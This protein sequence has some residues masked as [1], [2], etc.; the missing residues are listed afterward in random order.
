MACSYCYANRGLFDRPSG[1][2]MTPEAAQAVV[3]SA[4]RNFNSIEVVQFIGGEPTINLPAIECVCAAFAHALDEGKLPYIPRF[5]LTTNALSVSETLLSLART[6][7]VRITVSLDGPEEVH[8]RT[9]RTPDGKGTYRQV[10]SSI[11]R[12]QGFGLPL[13]FE[14]TFSRAH[15]HSGVHLID[16]C[17]WFREEFGLRVLHAPPVSAGSYVSDDLPLTN[18]ESIREYCSAAEW[19]VD[20]FIARN[21]LLA[22]SFTARVLKAVATKSRSQSICSAGSDLVC[23]SADGGIYPCWMFIGE[24]ALRIGNVSEPRTDAWDWTPFQ[25][26]FAP[27]DLESQECRACWAQPLCFGCRGAQFRATG[28]LEKKHNC[29]FTRAIVATILM[30]IFSRPEDDS[31]TD[32]YLSRTSLGELLFLESSEP[33]NQ[34]IDGSD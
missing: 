2:L 7:G 9:R 3:D 30:R 27:G 19:G 33:E 20:N 21:E 28:S 34:K 11:D 24:P 4:V 1:Q 15:L 26:L 13:D 18:A 8:N 32:A 22:D 17:R 16:L 5:A 31:S 10:R 25:R 6:Y 23:V 12:I 14:S 29:G